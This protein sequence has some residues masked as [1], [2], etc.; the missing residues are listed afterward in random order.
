MWGGSFPIKLGKEKEILGNRFFVS[1][2]TQLV[3]WG[4][5]QWYSDATVS[6]SVSSTSIKWKCQ[7]SWRA[8]LNSRQLKDCS[9]PKKNWV[10]NFPLSKCWKYRDRISLLTKSPNHEN[11]EPTLDEGW[12]RGI[13]SSWGFKVERSSF[14]TQSKNGWFRAEPTALG[15][16]LESSQVPSKMYSE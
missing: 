11:S 1:W 5:K 13:R 4:C 12:I 15:R 3:K 8:Q 16:P 2:L 10:W 14:W 7:V 6:I 9:K